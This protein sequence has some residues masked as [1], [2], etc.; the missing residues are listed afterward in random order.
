MKPLTR[1]ATA[2][3]RRA[4]PSQ[5]GTGRRWYPDAHEV[6]RDQVAEHGVTIEVASGILAALSPRMGWGMNVTLAERVLYTK[7]TLD[8]GCLSRSLEHANAI[9]HGAAPLEVLRGPKTRAFYLAI[10]TEGDSPDPVIDR[11]AWDMLTATRGAPAPSIGQYRA[12]AECMRRAARIVGERVHDLQAIDW[13][14]WRARFWTPGVN[15]HRP[16][17]T[18]EG[19]RQW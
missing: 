1:R 4:T 18:L 2:E 5:V 3:Y 9:Y 19:A 13:I 8:H 16:Q 12:A 6:A 11:H 7:G 17:P 15:D 14:A 10:L